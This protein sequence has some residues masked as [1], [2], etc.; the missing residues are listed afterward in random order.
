MRIVAGIA[1]TVFDRLVLNFGRGHCRLN[2][3]VAF[4]TEL[5]I[6]LE[7]QFRLLRLVG[8]V[9]GGTLT[10][11]HRLV[12]DFSRSQSLIRFFMAGRT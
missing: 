6:G 3:L 12:P 11:F 4:G 8:I 1:F 2:V 10:I 5:A 7:E 9:T